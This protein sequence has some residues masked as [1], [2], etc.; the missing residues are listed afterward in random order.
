MADEE[1]DKDKRAVRKRSLPNN[2]KD[3]VHDKSSLKDSYLDE[4]ASAGTTKKRVEKPPPPPPI[5]VKRIGKS[6][7]NVMKIV[8]RLENK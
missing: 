8:V 2:L 1:I 3:Y 5:P 6:Q 7:I 4:S